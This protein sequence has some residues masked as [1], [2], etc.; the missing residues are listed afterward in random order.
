VK[1][2]SGSSPAN[3]QPVTATPTRTL[4][5]HHLKAIIRGAAGR[6]KGGP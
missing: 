4:M 2:A 1:S 3:G 6:V 5:G